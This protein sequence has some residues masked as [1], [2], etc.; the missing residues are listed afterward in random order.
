MYDDEKETES[1]YSFEPTDEIDKYF[2]WKNESHINF[3]SNIGLHHSEYIRN[4]YISAFYSNID[5][6][7]ECKLNENICSKLYQDRETS[8]INITVSRK[9]YQPRARQL[10]ATTKTFYVHKAILAASSGKFREIFFGPAKKNGNLTIYNVC[11]DTFEQFI[12]CFYFQNV[13]FKSR[14]VPGVLN[15]TLPQIWK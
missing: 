10:T 3:H 4:I 6:S 15:N 13:S 7:V 12:R 5:C 8:D 14:Y 1:E 9:R 2:T 11:V